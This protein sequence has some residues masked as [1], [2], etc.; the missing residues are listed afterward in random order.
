MVLSLAAEPSEHILAT[1]RT[2]P[3]T[4]EYPV[5][6]QQESLLWL[7]PASSGSHSLKRQKTSCSL[8]GGPT[9]QRGI[10]RNAEASAWWGR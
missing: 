2:L 5:Y 1:K 9:G 6:L 4:P 10:E 3:L 8:G 7:F